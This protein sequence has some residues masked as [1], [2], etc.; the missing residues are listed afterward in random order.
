MCKYILDSSP[1][2]NILFL[3]KRTQFVKHVIFVNYKSTAA[4]VFRPVIFGLSS[5]CKPSAIMG[6]TCQSSLYC[7][8]YFHFV[9]ITHSNEGSSTRLDLYMINLTVAQ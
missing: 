3:V 1:F 5:R 4:L 9:K 8:S 2:Q 7:R 6:I